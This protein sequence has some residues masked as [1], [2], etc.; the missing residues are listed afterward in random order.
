MAGKGGNKGRVKKWSLLVYIAG[1]N[2]LSDAGLVDTLDFA[3]PRLARRER[4]R[5]HGK[6]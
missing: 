1:D 3:P 4:S 5:R 2:D 6:S